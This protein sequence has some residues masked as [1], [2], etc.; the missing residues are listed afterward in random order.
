MKPAN[1]WANAEKVYEAGTQTLLDRR[2]E[3]YAHFRNKVKDLYSS[4]D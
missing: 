2:D 1:T 3:M 4:G